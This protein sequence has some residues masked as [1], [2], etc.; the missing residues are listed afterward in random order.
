MYTFICYD[1]CGT[2]RKAEKWLQGNGIEYE[3]RP[4]KEENPTAQELKEWKEKSGL[5][6]KSFF[7]TS[8]QLYRSMGIKDKLK[9]MSDEEQFG[10]LATDGMLVKRPILLAGE[11][12]LVGFKEEQWEELK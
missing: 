2:C 3:K 6:L 12:V 11:R 1:R 7:N 10:L 4:I 9:D 8:G 5:P